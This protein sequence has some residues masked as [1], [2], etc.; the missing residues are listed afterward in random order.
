MEPANNRAVPAPEIASPDEEVKAPTYH[1]WTA[2]EIEEFGPCEHWDLASFKPDHQARRY[3]LDMLRIRLCL[4]W[5]AHVYPFQTKLYEINAT[6]KAFMNA[7][8]PSH[9]DEDNCYELQLV[10]LNPRTKGFQKVVARRG[11]TIGMEECPV[12]EW[13]IDSSQYSGKLP[14]SLDAHC[15]NRKELDGKYADPESAED[16][17]GIWE[18]DDDRD[19]RGYDDREPLRRGGRDER[20][21]RGD[22]LDDRDRRD[23][24]GDAPTYRDDRRDPLGYDPRSNPRP[25]DYDA[26]TKHAL[27]G[28]KWVP[29]PHGV[30]WSETQRQWIPSPPDP[31]TA[32]AVVGHATEEEPPLS[33][34]TGLLRMVDGSYVPAP[35][36]CDR[37][38]PGNWI[39]KPDPS[40]VGA[41]TNPARQLP[42]PPP[43]RPEQLTDDP[44][45]YLIDGAWLHCPAGIGLDPNTNAW[46]KR[47]DPPRLNK[48][49]EAPSGLKALS[50]PEIAAMF[51]GAGTAIAAIFSAVTGPRAE[52][53][54]AAEDRR[55]AEANAAVEK[56]KAEADA[57]KVAAQLTADAQRDVARIQA[58]AQVKAAELNAERER[59][60]RAAEEERKREE[61]DREREDRRT[62][63]SRKEEERKREFE[64]LRDREKETNDE[65][66]AREAREREDRA[67]AITREREDRDRA[68]KRD[69]EAREASEKRITDTLAAINAKP[70][71][72]PVDPLVKEL[73]ANMAELRKSMAPGGGGFDAELK[74]SI[75]IAERLGFQRSGGDTGGGSDAALTGTI[76]VTI[77]EKLLEFGDRLLKSKENG[78]HQPPPQQAHITQNALPPRAVRQGHVW[79]YDNG[80]FELPLVPQPTPLP[81][82]TAVPSS[83][84][85]QPPAENVTN[86]APY[87]QP[88][89]PPQGEPQWTVPQNAPPPPASD[90]E[91]PPMVG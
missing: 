60:A 8:G 34:S 6:R 40:R 32:G 20:R 3:A 71:A 25:P 88:P 21:D 28:G 4:K 29:A 65:R 26:A 33:K 67:A 11:L 37:I 18:A 85:P 49:T 74:R 22:R 9:H 87:T 91:L 69:R 15:L 63:E 42:A 46:V 24:F 57:A 44:T 68:E 89:A 80:W 56:A 17:E 48:Q 43:P 39:P 41:I 73:S 76:A 1:Q 54:R 7:W 82:G 77:A 59:A 2:E 75:A 86:S 47:P 31:A 90:D 38:G 61:R 16:E 12:R 52:A 72:P 66:R 10:G 35:F 83:P 84:A 19:V 70:A 58:E 36:G 30:Q 64:L 78:A 53:E 5:E 51:T 81:R 27:L 23:P 62:A 79:A 55:R 13:K 50:V 14:E 45:Y